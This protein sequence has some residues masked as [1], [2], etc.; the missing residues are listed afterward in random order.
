[1]LAGKPPFQGPTAQAVGL[2]ARGGALALAPGRALSMHAS[3]SLG[4]LTLA[5]AAACASAGPD[6]APAPPPPGSIVALVGGTI[7]PAPA[8][9]PVRDGAIVI[10]G[11][12]IIDV[13][14]RTRVAIPP[15]ATVIDCTGASM[16]AGFWNSHVHFTEPHWAGADTAAASRLSAQLAAMVTRWGFVHV[17]DTGSDLANTVALSRRIESGEVLGPEIRSAGMPLA[18]PGGTPFYLAPFRLPE[19]S[20]PADAVRLVS[21]RASMG[22][23]AVKLFVASPVVPGRPPVRMPP[24][25]I[26]A[27]A[28]AAQRRGLLVLAHP[29]DNAG[30]EAAARGGVDILLHTTPDGAAEWPDSTVAL[31]VRSG[32]ALVPTLQLWA[33]ELRRRNVPPDAIERFL[34]VARRQTTAFSRAGG[35]LL[36][37]TDVGYITEYDPTAEYRELSRAGI[38][39]PVVHAS[40][41]TAPAERLGA[42]VRAG[43]VATGMDGDVVVVDGN[44]ETDMT[45]LARV[46]LAVRRGR[47]VYRRE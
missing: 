39:F 7:F 29:T 3:R 20:S 22:A 30:A 12:V 8:A 31:L 32:I 15:E 36:F 41:T 45:A 38:T 25:V 19:L 1:M 14:P 4:S 27:A 6:P 40:L 42:A 46:R 21:E 5:A 18:P 9:R 34:D 43:R 11:G 37:G 44:P 33:F 28:G 35:T 16:L 2:T 10:R 13:G 26:R 17:L 47:I 23:R 24:A